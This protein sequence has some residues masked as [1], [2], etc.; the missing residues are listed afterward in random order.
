[1]HTYQPVRNQKQDKI[2]RLKKWDFQVVQNRD[3]L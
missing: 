2:K 1:M 3:I